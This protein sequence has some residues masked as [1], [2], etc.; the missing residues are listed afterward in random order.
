MAGYC[1]IAGGVALTMSPLAY[2]A[3]SRMATAPVPKDASAPQKPNAAVWQHVP[4]FNLYQAACLLAEVTPSYNSWKMGG[5]AQAWFETLIAESRAK[6]M[7][8]IPTIHDKKHTFSDG[9]HPTQET[10]ISRTELQRFAQRHGIR[11]GFLFPD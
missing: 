2:K 8:H 3:L 1:T 7:T 4:Q 5:D 9:Y 10:A 11:P 6:E